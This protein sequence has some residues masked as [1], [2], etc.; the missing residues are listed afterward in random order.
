MDLSIKKIL[1]KL[2]K[3]NGKVFLK[4]KDIVSKDLTLDK[5]KEIFGNDKLTD[6]SIFNLKQD[7]SGKLLLGFTDI[8]K[9]N[10]DLQTPTKI[11]NQDFLRNFKSLDKDPTLKKKGINI[12]KQI[13]IE[14]RERE[15]REIG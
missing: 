5:L 4:L 3:H 8:S 15:A 11:I 1:E 10:K 2:K 7:E 9:K 14:A 13:D 12:N 6:N